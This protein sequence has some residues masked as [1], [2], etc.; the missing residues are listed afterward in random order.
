MLC[1]EFHLPQRV[2]VA[3]TQGYREHRAHE[4]DLGAMSTLRS[5]AP[6]VDAIANGHLLRWFKQMALRGNARHYDA[7][8]VCGGSAWLLPVIWIG[9]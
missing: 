7:H 3:N 9:F 6:N 5:S 2:V 8:G 4:G 1:G